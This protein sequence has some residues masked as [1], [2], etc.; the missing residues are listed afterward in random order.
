MKVWLA[1]HREIPEIGHLCLNFIDDYNNNMNR[2]DIVDQLR[3][4][5]TRPLDEE[6][7]MVVGVFNLGDW[8]CRCQRI[9]NV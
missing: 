3:N 9:Q 2:A 7:E 8:S 1:M 4:Q 5:S 6:L